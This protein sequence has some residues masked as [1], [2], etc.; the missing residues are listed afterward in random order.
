[1]RKTV[2]RAGSLRW[3]SGPLAVFALL[4]VVGGPAA[5]QQNRAMGTGESRDPQP[6]TREQRLLEAARQG[7]RAVVERALELGAPVEARDDLGRSVLLL[8]V[9]DAR[10]LSLVRFLRERGASVDVA[11]LAGRTPLS[12]AA[13][14]GRLDLVAYLVGQGARIDAADE[15]G[16]TPLFHAVLGNHREVVDWLLER[17]AEVDVRD[18]FR[19]TPLILACAKGH[20]EMAALLRRHAA[21]PTLRDQEG[22]SLP[23]RSAIEVEACRLPS[24]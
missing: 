13:A 9:R 7:D 6:F 2:G 17:G 20:A 18:R 1:M 4:V 8:A 3:A 11:D 10:D 16:R 12:F 19:D 14:S 24:S 15:R 21:D 23:E 5:G 22:R